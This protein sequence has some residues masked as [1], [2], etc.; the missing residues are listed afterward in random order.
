MKNT[1]YTIS[2]ILDKNSADIEYAQCGHVA[3]RGPTGSCKHIVAMCYALEDSCHVRQLR[4]YVSNI[5]LLQ[6]W[7]QPQNIPWKPLK[8][9]TSSM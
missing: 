8:S 9:E 3:G 4:E 6:T 2:L 5:S 1:I 7:N